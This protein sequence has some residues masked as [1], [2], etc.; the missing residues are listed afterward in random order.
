MHFDVAELAG[1]TA[2]VVNGPQVEVDGISTDSRTLRPGQLFVPLHDQRDGHQFIAGAVAAGAPAYLTTGPLVPGATA[3]VV[4]GTAAALSAIGR[5]ARD[6]FGERVIG[7]TGSVGKTT[8]KD[9]LASVLATTYETASSLRSFNNEIGVPLTLA[10]A[11]DGA[12]AVVVELGARGFGHIR[13]LC[14]VARPT[15]GVVTRVGSAHTEFFGDLDAVATAKSELVECLPASGTAVLNA[16]DPRVLAMADRAPCAVVLFGLASPSQVTAR[17]VKMD[18]IARPT[19]RLVTPDGAADVRMAL[20]GRHQVSNAL[21]AAG[22]ALAAGVPLDAVAEG[23]A[24]TA[25]AP[26]R[27]NVIPAASGA[28]VVN[29]AYNA[30][31]S[32]M[33]AALEAVAAFGGRR[34]VAVLGQMTELGPSSL[35]D[36]RAVVAVAEALG[37]EVVAYR[38]DA[39]GI[40]PV[41]DDEELARRLLPLEPDDVVL[42]K[43]SRVAGLEAVA[44]L[45]V[46]TG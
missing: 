11:A 44:D 27:M 20:S 33:R 42:V 14:D 40:D 37:I 31:P 35:D 2:G 8:V 19:F 18:R 28:V 17:D 38:T 13:T 24:T 9:L 21:A 46:G 30:N 7:V 1:V 36:H 26:W 10:N 23:L 15:I 41:A 6:R 4:A 16:D 32:S 39:Y 45:L 34:K 43:G 5:A 22:A 29:D 25:P 12:E 3:V